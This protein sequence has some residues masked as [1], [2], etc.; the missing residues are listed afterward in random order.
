[1]KVGFILCLVLILNG[2]RIALP[3]VVRADEASTNSVA[4]TKSLPGFD[5]LSKLA[6]QRQFSIFFNSNV[7]DSLTP[8]QCNQIAII[9]TKS[10]VATNETSGANSA[11]YDA[12]ML[13]QALND[14]RLIQ[15]PEVIPYLIDRLSVTTREDPNFINY[16][17]LYLLNNLT[18]R[19]VGFD[20]HGDVTNQLAIADWWKN[21]WQENKDLHPLY[22]KQL[23][24][25]LRNE[26]FATD[27]KITE[28][29]PT[30]D[31]AWDS[32]THFLLQNNGR[33][34]QGGERNGGPRDT[35]FTFY[36]G[37]SPGGGFKSGGYFPP[38]D[39][40]LCLC[41]EFLTKN[42]G[43]TDEPLYGVTSGNKTFLM[44]EVSSRT[45]PATGIAIKVEIAT[46]NVALVNFLREQNLGIHF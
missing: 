10:L 31:F 29:K 21:W 7:V 2:S 26:I 40:V 25:I 44:Q 32:S 14:H 19:N 9:A 8:E 3:N 24:A 27:A 34:G 18:G 6:R 17:L 46:T 1:M 37:H 42:P 15:T 45:V 16:D 41:G 13:L 12:L 22:D 28:A 38:S 20:S 36:Y 43:E 11:Q 30:P 39:D 33:V 4:Q 5:S 35:L 23:E